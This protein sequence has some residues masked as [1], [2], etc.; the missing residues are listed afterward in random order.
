MTPERLRALTILREKGAMR[1]KAFALA[2]WPDAP[3]HIRVTM[4]GNNGSSRGGG[5][6]RAAGSFLSRL[7]SLGLVCRNH[8]YRT[9]GITKAG[10]AAVEK[11]DV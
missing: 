5:M 8:E 1:P 4:C 3:G 10:L 7:S 11:T 2:M 9:Y 6:W